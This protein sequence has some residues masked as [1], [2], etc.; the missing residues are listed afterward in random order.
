MAVHVADGELTGAESSSIKVFGT[1]RILEVARLLSGVVGAAGYLTP[2]SPGAL[3]RGRLEAT[4]RQ[5]QVNTFGGGVN[6]VQREIVASAGLGMTRGHGERAG[7]VPRARALPRQQRGVGRVGG[8]GGGLAQPL[9][10]RGEHADDPP[11]GRGDGRPQPDLRV[12]PGGPGGRLRRA[13]R[14]PDHAP[15]LDHARAASLERGRGGPRRG[16]L[17]GRGPDGP[18]D[19]AARRGGPHVGRGHQLRAA[20]RTSP[21]DR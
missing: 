11:L 8:A 14:A 12:G 4:G 3:L 21:R 13:D 20:V 19:A 2:G 9:A 17:A 7:A 15:G 16:D 6:E 5:A 18:H 10:G 1:E